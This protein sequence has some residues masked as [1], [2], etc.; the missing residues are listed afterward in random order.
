MGNQERVENWRKN[1]GNEKQNVLYRHLRDK[2]DIPS[3]QALKMKYWSK[4]NINLWLI[5]NGYVEGLI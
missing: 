5:E 1:G 3:V 4:K 2:Y